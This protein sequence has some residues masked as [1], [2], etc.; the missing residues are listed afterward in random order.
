MEVLYALAQLR[1]PVGDVLMSLITRL[2]EETIFMAVAIII[3]WCR[4]KSAGYYLLTVGFLGTLAN[5]LL[6]ML[7]RIP[8]PWVLDPDLTIVESARE[9]ATGYSFPSGH[10]QSAAGLF[11]GLARMS[12]RRWVQVIL[13]LAV[14]LVAFS[15]MYLGVHTPWDVGVSLVI[16]AVLVLVLW[17]VMHRQTPRRMLWILVGMLGCSVAYLLFMLYW[18]FPADTDAANLAS[19]IENGWKL[20]GATIGMLAACW[21][22]QRYIRF[23]TAAPLKVQLLKVIPGLLLLVALQ[24]GLKAPLHQLIGHT[25]WADLIRYCLVVVF[26][27]ALWPL[28]F[29]RFARW[30]QKG[31]NHEAD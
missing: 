18:Q 2:G 23:E 5:Q 26:A 11:G 31:E 9:A 19:A 22:D 8:R 13:V 3:Y 17:P 14:V 28:T 20:T 25:G 7:C 1:T 24:A 10:T 4:S 29:R 15:R 12:R 16:G 21:L 30:G 6:K 27:G